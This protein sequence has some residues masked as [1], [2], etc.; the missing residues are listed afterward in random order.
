MVKFIET[1]NKEKGRR[2]YQVAGVVVHIA[3]GST[4]SV[5]AEFTSPKT[6]KSSHYHVSRDG[7]VIQFVQESD[8][9]WAQ[10]RVNNPTA[11]LIRENLDVN[12]NAFLVSIEEEDFE[13]KQNLKDITEAQ[14]QTSAELIYDICQRWSIPLDRVR[15]IGHRE[16]N[17]QKRCPENIDLDRLVSL[18]LQVPEKRKQAVSLLQR[19]IALFQQ[20]IA[21]LTKGRISNPSLGSMENAKGFLKSKR[22]WANGLA[23]LLFFATLFGV[24][25]DMETLDKLSKAMPILLPL[26]N[27][28]FIPFSS[29]PVTF[30][31]AL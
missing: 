20:L 26:L 2:G 24:T 10:G 17:A 1:P 23:I 30:G 19:L 3:D 11:T 29:R 28:L 31:R 9:A 27:L 21:M 13:N 8:T 18:A 12:P 5:I 4:Q 25:P 22:V 7:S 14:Y 16:I 15:V 6:Q